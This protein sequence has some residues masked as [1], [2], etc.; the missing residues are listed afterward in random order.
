M[1]A[2]AGGKSAVILPESER[3]PLGCRRVRVR[4]AHLRSR[5][6]RQRAEGREVRKEG[7]L[8]FPLWRSPAL[9]A[10]TASATRAQRSNSSAVASA[11]IVT[12]CHVILLRIRYTL[13][14]AVCRM[15]L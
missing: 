3:R 8:G 2:K 4:Y 12:H 11:Q 7:N 5:S 10:G 15:N 1:E 6:E 9:R 13:V 14:F